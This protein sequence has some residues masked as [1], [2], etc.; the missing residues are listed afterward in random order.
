MMGTNEIYKLSIFRLFPKIFYLAGALAVQYTIKLTLK[1]ALLLNLLGFALIVVI[2]L[3]LLKPKFT[4][5]KENW[6]MLVAENKTYGLQVYISHLANTATTR[7]AAVSIAYFIDNTNVGYYALALTITAPLALIPRVVGT[8][9]FKDFANRDSIPGKATAATVSLAA[10]ALLIFLL[11]IKTLF[12]IIYTRDFAPALPIVYFFAFSSVIH[13]F[14]DYVNRFLGA[15]GKGKDMRNSGF[16][17]AGANLLGYVLLVYYFQLD[18][19]IITRVAASI[20]Y[21]VSMLYFYR[22]LRKE[23]TAE[24]AE[25]AGEKNPH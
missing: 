12:Y 15:H 22:K 7:V 25:S 24:A 20:I 19:A 13:G 21:L 17:V 16:I 5:V 9:F 4:K 8:T 3:F 2:M 23:S 14:A 10:G 18:G 6:R 1:A 11:I